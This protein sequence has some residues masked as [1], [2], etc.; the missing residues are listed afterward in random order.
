MVIHTPRL[1]LCQL[2]HD[3]C[4]FIVQLVNEPAF[5]EH[6]GDRKVFD[7]QSAI[8]Y[9]DNG[10]MASYQAEGFGLL[11]VSIAHTG[12]AIGVCGLVFRDYLPFPDLGF[13]MLESKNR[14]GFGYESSIAILAYARQEL[15]LSTICAITSLSNGPSIALLKRLGFLAPAIR[16]EAEQLSNLTYFELA[17]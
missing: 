4:D 9:L 11:K 13:A 1:T 14:Q 15:N 8:N 7:R 16:P 6:I 17:L 5:L 3:D 2:S 10:P 12:Q